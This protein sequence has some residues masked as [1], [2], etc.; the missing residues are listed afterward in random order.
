MIGNYLKFSRVLIP[1]GSL[2][3]AVSLIALPATRPQD[4]QAPPDNTVHNRNQPPP[5][6]D[7]QNT[8]P[9]DRATT[10]KI[11]KAIHDDSSLSSY[12]HNVKII[13]QNGKVTLRGPVRSEEEK[14]NIQS[15]AAA[16]AGDENVI[17]HL[18]VAP[19]SN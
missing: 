10:Q 18:K 5:T 12:A 8:N 9:E 16:V 6:A 7:Q 3:F 13:T 4:P 15:K 11:R 14:N 17:N 1:L 19:P 2:A